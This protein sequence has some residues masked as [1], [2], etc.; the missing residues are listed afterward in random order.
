[1]KQHKK[2]KTQDE[3]KGVRSKWKENDLLVLLVHATFYF[4]PGSS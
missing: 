3:D 2:I 4:F 1:M